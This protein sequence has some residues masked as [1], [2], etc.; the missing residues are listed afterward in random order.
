MPVFMSCRRL[1]SL[2]VDLNS[3]RDNLVSK[4]LVALVTKD[5]Q[6]L[7][8]DLRG[9]IVR[10][11]KEIENLLERQKVFSYR[12]VGRK[13]N[14]YLN[15]HELP[16]G[17]V[18]Q[19]YQDLAKD[20]DM[21]ERTLQQCEQFVR[22][23]PELEWHKNLKWSHYR[24]LLTVPD[25]AERR[26]WLARIIKY[27]IPAN[28]VRLALMP[29][30]K[31]KEARTLKTPVQGKLFTYRL[32][33]AED[34]D[35]FDVPWFVDVGFAGRCE[36]PAF[37]GV[38]NNKYLYACEKMKDSYRL[39]VV[40]AKVDELFT[41]RGVVRRVIDGDTLVV[42][43]DQGFSMWCEQRLRLFGID[44]PELDTLAGK[45][46]KKWVEHELRNSKNV[47][48]KT[49]KSDN[50]DRYLVDIFYIPKEADM[51]RVAAQGQWLNGKM[52]DAGIANVWKSGQRTSDQSIV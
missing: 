10:G 36:A 7:V 50:W 29:P 9:E 51:N 34:V 47:V 45:R 32:L 13:I 26:T 3:Q 31:N 46:A 19:F 52:V 6:K 27:K 8:A 18:G 28:D 25:A 33:R 43:V 49:Y 38:L 39:K 14:A 23:F 2:P 20:L 30:A 17:A 16:R 37:D 12:S 4:T 24:F 21:N 44:T 42:D 11:I 41:F 48:V 15:A 5:Y 1:F 40:D 22:Y 35:N